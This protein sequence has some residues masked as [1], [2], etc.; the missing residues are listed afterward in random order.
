MVKLDIGKSSPKSNKQKNDDG[1]GGF[2]GFIYFDRK[3][4]KIGL[5]GSSVSMYENVTSYSNEIE[6]HE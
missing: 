6:K 3:E 5:R 4:C 2:V 1:S